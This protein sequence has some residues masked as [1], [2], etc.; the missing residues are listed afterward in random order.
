MEFTIQ[1]CLRSLQ[2][3]VDPLITVGT[4]RQVPCLGNTD[5]RQKAATGQHW[6]GVERLKHRLSSLLSDLPFT[7]T[8]CY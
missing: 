2:G 4:A 1:Q 6:T 3:C 8:K 5:Y 7:T